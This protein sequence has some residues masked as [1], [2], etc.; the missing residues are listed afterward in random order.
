MLPHHN[1]TVCNQGST[2][3]TNF[4]DTNEYVATNIGV[5]GSSAQSNYCDSSDS[6]TYTPVAPHFTLVLTSSDSV[7]ST[8]VAPCFTPVLTVSDTAESSAEEDFDLLFSKM[9]L[10]TFKF[11][12]DNIDLYIRPRQETMDHHALSLH[13]THIILSNLS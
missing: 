11:V 9:P 5:Y 4:D 7:T 2:N 8:P 1:E 3:E 12:A 6:A 10:P 13:C